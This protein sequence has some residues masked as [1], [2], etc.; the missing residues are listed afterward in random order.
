MQLPIDGSRK[1]DRGGKVT[2]CS[3]PRKRVSA[4]AALGGS[5]AEHNRIRFVSVV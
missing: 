1:D 5:T 2:C 3:N 4:K